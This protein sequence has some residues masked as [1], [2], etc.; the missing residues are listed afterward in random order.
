[1]PYSPRLLLASLLLSTTAAA[2]DI[3]PRIVGGTPAEDGDFPFLVALVHAG[4]GNNYDGQ[5][6]GGSVIHPRWVLTAAHCVEDTRAAEV[7]VVGGRRVMSA[8]SAEGRQAVRSIVVHPAYN[9]ITQRNDIA[10]LQLAEASVQPVVGL[11]DRDLVD[12]LSSG[13]RVRAAG[14]GAVNKA[15]TAYPRALQEVTLPFLTTA[16]CNAMGVWTPALTDTQVCTLDT[17][18]ERDTCFGDSGGPLTASGRLLGLTSFG[19][20]TC[21]VPD[22]PGVYTSVAAFRDWIDSVVGTA[23]LRLALARD[24]AAGPRAIT[25]TASNEG[26]TATAGRPVLTLALPGY[27]LEATGNCSAERDGSLSCPLQALAAG[28]TA[29]WTYDLG[30]AAGPAAVLVATVGGVADSNTANNSARLRLPEVSPPGDGGGSLA[31]FLLA[32][33]ALRRAGRQ[34]R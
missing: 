34:G 28:A 1:M 22:E 5:F 31:P 18:G 26:T 9:R 11:A 10:L 12:T 32:A 23:D 3:T 6:C 19:P 4:A 8:D 17:G 20:D 33:L 29:S 30:T 27:E 14:W 21:A 15:G 25:V 2:A 24:E 13:D 16:D 7:T